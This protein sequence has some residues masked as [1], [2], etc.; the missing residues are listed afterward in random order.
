M[1]SI[2][3]VNWNTRDLLRACL[4]SLE[5]V[6]IE[7]EVIVVDCA[8]SDESAAMVAREFSNVR[9]IA[10]A[11]NLGF[12]AGNNRAYDAATGEWI[13]L[14]NPDT[15]IW[16]NAAEVLIEFLRN[17]PN[18]GAVASALVDAHRGCVQRSCRTFPTPAA[19]WAQAS[20]LAA[21]FPRSKRFGFYKMGWWNYRDAR[22]VEQ[23]MASSLM[24]RRAAIQSIGELFD[25]QFPIFFNDVDLCYRLKQAGWQIWFEPRSRVRHWGGAATS[26]IKPEMI[27]QSHA[28]LRRFY[29]K[30]YRSHVAAPLYYATIW[31]SELAGRARILAAKRRKKTQKD[32]KKSL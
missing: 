6:T 23:P 2:L 12:A 17:H 29:A 19:L 14:L 27:A 11:Q 26:Q 31:M 5:K 30:H 22:Q 16:E 18:A 25:E 7:H 28:S 24:L 20:G 8:S 32:G 21:L 9:S 15:E 3:I 1:L 10:S 4:R 13:W